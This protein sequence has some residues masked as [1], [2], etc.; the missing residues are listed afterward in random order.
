[1]TG[2]PASQWRP[3]DEAAAATGHVAATYDEVLTTLGSWGVEELRTRTTTVHDWLTAQGAAFTS[4][5]DG[6]PVTAPLPLDVVPRVLSAADWDH[7]ATGV[8]QRSRALAAFLDDL[9]AGG[10]AV[11]DGI[12]PRDVVESSPGRRTGPANGTPG[13]RL[14]VTG[15]DILRGPDGWLVLED[16][17]QVP[18]GTVYALLARE[19]A[20][21]VLGELHTSHPKRPLHDVGRLLLESLQAAAPEAAVSRG[22]GDPPVVVLLSDGPGNSAWFEHQRLAE[23]MGI[24]VVGPADLDGGADGVT[25]PGSGPDGGRITVDVVYRR[26]DEAEL[27]ATQLREGRTA[28]DVLLDAVAAGRLTLANAL[29]T[30]IADDKAVYP[31]VPAMVEYYL[32]ER[33]VLADVPT[34]I[35][36]DETRLA[37]VLDRLDELVLKPVDGYGGAG[38]YFGATAEAAERERMRG[39]LLADPTRWIAQEPVAFSTHPTV[40]DGQLEPRHVDLRVFAAAGPAGWQALPVPLTRVAIKAGSL[41]V[42]SS[43]GGGTKDT[44]VVD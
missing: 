6:T 20:D 1:M 22:T 17:A 42:N 40:V 38:L 8:T 24:P 43:S 28:Y 30:G 12:V 9:E 10:D 13:R 16:N 19:A 23:L 36:R 15:L 25:V 34:W 7:V 3:V 41:V 14:V 33:P 37:E 44:W 26:T 21:A 35:C 5:V 32:G 4:T 18:S 2:D 11:A 29:G 27:R 31:Y 39:Q